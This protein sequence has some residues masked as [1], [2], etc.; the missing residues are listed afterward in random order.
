MRKPYLFVCFTMVV[1]P[2]AFVVLFSQNYRVFVLA[3]EV[4]C[5]STL[6]H[7][8]GKQVTA[9]ELLR[10]I[11]RSRNNTFASAVNRARADLLRRCPSLLPSAMSKVGVAPGSIDIIITTVNF[12]TS[13]D[14]ASP[15]HVKLDVGKENLYCDPR[16]RRDGNVRK[17]RRTS[18]ER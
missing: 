5:G 17:R 8:S 16:S 11:K 2:I 12:T 18:T 15:V 4:S 6:W 3:R 1:V 14:P 10:I 7:I 9:S 13:S